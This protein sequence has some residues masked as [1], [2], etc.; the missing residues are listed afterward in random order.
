MRSEFADIRRRKPEPADPCD[1]CDHVY[2][3]HAGPEFG[4]ECRIV[5]GR[6]WR[7]ERVP[8]GVRSKKCLCD[9]FEVKA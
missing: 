7:G 3:S 6:F 1:R 9:R 8:A 4:R 2:K 5:D